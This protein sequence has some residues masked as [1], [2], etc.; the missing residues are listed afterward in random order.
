MKDILKKNVKFITVM[1]LIIVFGVVGITYAV[2]IGKFNPILLNTSTAQ[3]SANI[4]Y[5]SGYT[6]TITNTGKMLPISDSS[7]TGASVT[8]ARVLKAEFKVTGS[9]SNPEKSIYDI[10]LRDITMD[11]VLKSEDVKWRLYRNGTLISSGSFAPSFDIMEN[12]RLV[13]TNEQIDMTTS[14]DTFTFLMWISESCTGDITTC[15]KEMDQS[16]YF[17]KKFTAVVKLE[18]SAK[19]KKALV[20]KHT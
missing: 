16:K 2:K 17:G 15:T 10:V 19:S 9:S 14:T 1:L 13:L 7:I 4:T 6:S 11:S 5:N 12:N 8:D 18:A 3:I 20:R